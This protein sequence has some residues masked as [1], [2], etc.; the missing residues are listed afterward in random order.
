MER[1]RLWQEGPAPK[2]A[3]SAQMAGAM[4]ARWTS[5]LKRSLWGDIPS[6]IGLWKALASRRLLPGIFVGCGLPPIAAQLESPLRGHGPYVE[7]G[8]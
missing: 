4:A 3:G 8:P 2:V 7:L 6:P 1:G 5:P